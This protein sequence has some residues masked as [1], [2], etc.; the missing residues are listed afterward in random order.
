MPNEV[1]DSITLDGLW[2]ELEEFQADPSIWTLPT[3]PDPGFRHSFFYNIVAEVLA[4]VIIIII[5]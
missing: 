1:S 4:C 3:E 2:D 5:V